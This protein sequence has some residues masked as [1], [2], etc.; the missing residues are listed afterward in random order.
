MDTSDKD[1]GEELQRYIL[2]RSSSKVFSSASN[3]LSRWVSIKMDSGW[4]PH[5]SPQIVFESDNYNLIQA[6]IKN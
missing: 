3:K 1:S 6:M 4:I 5:G 2:I